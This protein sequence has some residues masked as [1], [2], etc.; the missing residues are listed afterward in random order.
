MN[1]M[2]VHV[3]RCQ[4]CGSDKMKNILVRNPGDRD[5]VYV[6]C[7]DC[8]SFVASYIIAP[9]GYY[10]HGKGYESFLRSMIRSGDMMSGRKLQHFF[11]ERKTKDVEQFKKILEELKKKEDHTKPDQ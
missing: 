5:R 10:H 3:Q 6:Q 7:Q 1:F 11:E 9:M 2:D 8:E 4:F